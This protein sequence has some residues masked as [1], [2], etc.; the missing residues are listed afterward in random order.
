MTTLDRRSLFAASVATLAA[1]SY[2][3]V[4]TGQDRDTALLDR[5][6]TRFAVN[7]E[8]WWSKLPFVE[9]IKKTADSGLSAIEFWPWRGKNLDEVE[10]TCKD[11]NIEIAQF[12]AW[13]FSPGMNDPAHHA[14]VVDEI[15][16]SCKVA[17]RLSCKAM[18]V[19]A[20]NDQPGM[21]REQ[22][23]EHV[24]TALKLC[25][26]I[27]RDHDVTLIL[28]P[29]NGRVDHPGH[30]LYGSEAA[31]RICKAVNSPHVKINWDLYHMQMSEGD[32]CGHLKEGFEWLG[33]AQVADA[34]GRNE[35]GTGEVHYPR[36]LK[37][38]HELGYRGCVGLECWPRDG[39]ETALQRVRESDR[40]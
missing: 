36:V 15:K 4:V 14:K 2:G 10:K 12:T 11:L 13:G 32:L 9:R 38:L 7:A 40:W 33:Y 5:P 6:R 37:A 22:M 25:A 24:I 18:T 30:C 26:P 35:P 16:E 39:E 1:Q 17:N 29:M 28:E 8:I 23:H 31:V 3:S 21:S 27:A 19:V 20:G 34:P